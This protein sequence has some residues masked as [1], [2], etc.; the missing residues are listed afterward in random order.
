[1]NSEIIIPPLDK[2]K[3]KH[4][5]LPNK[6]SVLLISDEDSDMASAAMAVNVGFFAD[7]HDAQGLAHFLEHMLFMGTKTYPGEDYYPAHV[8]KHGGHTNAYT[9]NE[10]T[11]YFFDM[12]HEHFKKTLHIFS[13]YFI[14]PLLNE[15]SIDKEMNAVNSEFIKNLNSDGWR[16][17]AVINELSNKSYP[18]H[19]FGI[20]SLETLKKKNI[21]EKLIK[22][23]KRY[24]SANL[25]RL[26]LYGPQKI[27][28]L[29]S[30]AEKMFGIVP[31]YNYAKLSYNGMPFDIGPTKCC[32]LVKIKPIRN[33]NEI[34]I[35]WQVNPTRKYYKLDPL[36]Y[37][38]YMIEH[39]EHNTLYYI[40]RNLGWCNSLSA[41]ESHTDDNVSLFTVKIDTTETGFKNK[42]EIIKLI[43]DYIELI[44]KNGINERKYTEY[45]EIM[46]LDFNYQSKSQPIDYV[47][48]LASA[49]LHFKLKYILSVGL[50]LEK[51]STSVEKI[52][53]AY[54]NSMTSK[55][56]IVILNSQKYDN[57][58]KKEKWFKVEY[59]QYN[60]IELFKNILN[61]D[62]VKK[63]GAQ[64]P[65]KNR[66]IPKNLQLIKNINPKRYPIIIQDNN[67]SLVWYKLNTQFKIPIVNVVVHY[68]TPNILKNVKNY[69]SSI[70]FVLCL[71]EILNPKMYSASLLRSYCDI[72]TSNEMLSIRIS[73]YNDNIIKLLDMCL[74]TIKNFKISKKIFKIVQQ[75]LIQDF[76]NIKFN[77]PHTHVLDIYKEKYNKK[78]MGSIEDRIN[79]I[80]KLTV[81]DIM[82]VSEW[83]FEDSHVR[84][85][86]EGNIEK[87]DALF[88][89][90]ICQEVIVNSKLPDKNSYINEST[91][92][93]TDVTYRKVLNKTEL[94]SVI[95]YIIEIEH[96]KRGVT[97]GWEKMI[98]MIKLLHLIIKDMF[99][100]QLRTKEQL[101]Y[102]VRSSIMNTDRQENSLYNYLYLIQSPTKDPK[103]L[104]ERIDSFIIKCH[105]KLKNITEEEFKNIVS[106]AVLKQKKK[107]DNLSESFKKNSLILIKNDGI[108]NDKKIYADTFED[109]EK[110]ELIDFYYRYFVNLKTK[111]AKIIGLFG[112]NHKLNK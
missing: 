109:I 74:Y 33:V 61:D 94:N 44:K 87:K 8:S 76:E 73:G 21:R 85:L 78:Y 30:Y 83:L 3:Y 92:G 86:M 36:G 55:N 32:K 12:Q 60:N 96:I 59:D 11:V 47:V 103:Y 89:G 66:F 91:E 37:F 104:K 7:P 90:D 65:Q 14:D 23:Y 77:P 22:F 111:K 53:F 56:A 93:S 6:L 102:F 97:E 51:Y 63:Y 29:E 10:E 101:G 42:N 1:M 70:M 4:I 9:H 28:E 67:T 54:V 112:N 45:R 84:C 88:I 107:Y 58:K 27:D 105:K 100:D 62:I 110:E 13:R 5:T 35:V 52:L 19:N 38:R 41:F 34:S 20:G 17:N 48:D 64:L 57:L 46:K 99:F 25:M 68:S 75:Q 106:T 16:E 98:C 40:L 18:L 50:L 43:F 24:Y 108:F 39:E 79:E 95:F 26:V 72:S 31:N 80:K 71:S 2:R 15:K 82:E 81:N 69:V 49:M